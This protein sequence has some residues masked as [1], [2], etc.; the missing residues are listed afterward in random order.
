M[1][2]LISDPVDSAT[3]GKVLSEPTLYAEQATRLSNAN[4]I[5]VG[6][7]IQYDGN[8]SITSEEFANKLSQIYL[9]NSS[10]RS[11]AVLLKALDDNAH[12]SDSQLAMNSKHQEAIFL[13]AFVREFKLINQGY[14]SSDSQ[15][16]VSDEISSRKLPSAES[17]EKEIVKEK[18]SDMLEQSKSSNKDRERSL[19]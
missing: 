6:S 1:A 17:S 7:N 3:T 16:M 2:S 13:A 11:K 10:L 8:I 4:F 14:S 12:S 18:L 5:K 15:K 9:D 19:G